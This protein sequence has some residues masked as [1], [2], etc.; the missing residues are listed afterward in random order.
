MNQKMK[1]II[2]ALLITAC[3]AAVGGCASVD[4]AQNDY[5]ETRPDAEQGQ[6][7][8]KEQDQT[9]PENT[10]GDTDIA[11][12]DSS[13]PETAG[14]EESKPDGITPGEYWNRPD[15]LIGGDADEELAILVNRE[16]HD[17]AEWGV[18]EESLM[19]GREVVVTASH[20]HGSY[21][22]NGVLKVFVTTASSSY[23][24]R[25]NSVKDEA[26]TVTPKVITFLKTDDGSYRGDTF[27][28]AMDGSEFELSIRKFC[29]TP[30]GKDIS[31]L[32][33]SMIDYYMDY[34][35]IRELQKV[36]LT[37][38]FNALDMKG[39]KLYEPGADPVALT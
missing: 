34:S 22:E 5:G 36:K 32:A 21:E 17:A 10:S 18:N 1:I 29:K 15:T 14:G 30:S 7:Q 26:G 8:E 39:M 25:E 3:L 33:D 24:V 28:A 6:E 23:S 16:E 38:Y 9:V 31:G 19:F 11:D 20:V 35:D 13:I 27:E 2:T 12:A 37:S 4:D